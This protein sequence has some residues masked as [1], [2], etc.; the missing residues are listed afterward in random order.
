MSRQVSKMVFGNKM[1]CKGF[2]WCVGLIL[3]LALI[4]PSV[5]LSS[6]D[7][8]IDDKEYQDKDFHKG[9]IADYTDMV[10]GDDVDWVWVKSGE[11]LS[12][13]K[14]KIGTMENKSDLHR[15]SFGE[16]VKSIFED[17]LPSRTKGSKE[18]L[19]AEL[20]ITE[21]QEYSPGK[22]W[23]P[24]AGGRLMQAGIGI[25]MILR[26]QNNMIVAKLRHFDRH[27]TDVIRAAEDV[28]GHMAKYI[29]RH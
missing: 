13:Y 17:Y 9:I 5:A 10:K 15:K 19:T 4:I 29:S 7:R 16:S 6:S 14:I 20:C 24:F 8:L 23:I 1:W 2:V 25:E 18:T 28:A 26:D 3:S 12:Q 22:A 27:G 21:V 11:N